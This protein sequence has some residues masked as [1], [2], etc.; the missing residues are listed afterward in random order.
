MKLIPKI[1]AIVTVLL[2]VSKTLPMD[3]R[4]LS[5]D[6]AEES[7]NQPCCIVTIRVSVPKNGAVVQILNEGDQENDQNEV[8]HWLVQLVKNPEDVQVITNEEMWKWCQDDTIE[9]AVGGTH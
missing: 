7:P 3:L 2:V 6:A 5:V 9:P 1:I 8:K 4:S